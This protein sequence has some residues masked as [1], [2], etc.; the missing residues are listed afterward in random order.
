MEEQRE[1]I[2]T[3][4]AQLQSIDARLDKLK[5]SDDASAFLAALQ[6]V[7]E[8]Y[9]E[10]INS[11]DDA[12]YLRNFYDDA[13]DNAAEDGIERAAL[14]EERQLIDSRLHAAKTSADELQ[15]KADHAYQAFTRARDRLHGLRTPRPKV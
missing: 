15:T 1:V 9:K 5:R 11:R 2:Q 10:H 4:E 3:A 12:V 7:M 13:V 8:Q 14:L 6:D